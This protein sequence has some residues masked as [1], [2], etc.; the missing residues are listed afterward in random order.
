MR[1]YSTVGRL[2]NIHKQ[3]ATIAASPVQPKPET[4][5]EGTRG[6]G[7]SLFSLLSRDPIKKA[8]STPT[9][10]LQFEKSR[11]SIPTMS[12]NLFD[13]MHC[14]FRYSLFNL[15]PLSSMVLN[16]GHLL[17]VPIGA[18]HLMILSHYFY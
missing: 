18:L 16:N 6:K 10:R 15:L 11:Q 8:E 7:I 14:N 9:V 1:R 13:S 4:R 3:R 2:S 12:T 5:L 17:K